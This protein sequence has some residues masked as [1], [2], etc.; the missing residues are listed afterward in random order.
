MDLE[1]GTGTPSISQG[2]WDKDAPAASCVPSTNQEQ[3]AECIPQVCGLW[4]GTGLLQLSPHAMHVPLIL[5]MGIEPS[6]P[7]PQHPHIPITSPE[8]T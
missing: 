5:V 2:P 1:K 6:K 3:V 7:S 4:G 8:W